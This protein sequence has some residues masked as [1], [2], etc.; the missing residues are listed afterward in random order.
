MS[1][2]QNTPNRVMIPF[3]YG[4][5]SMD[6]LIQI[7]EYGG[8]LFAD[9]SRGFNPPPDF[10]ECRP[11]R[12]LHENG[13]CEP[14]NPGTIST[15]YSALECEGCQ[16]GKSSFDS[17]GNKATASHCYDCPPGRMSASSGVS[18]CALC[19]EGHFSS[20]WGAPACD[21]CG[22]GN[23]TNQRGASQCT[24]CLLYTSDAADE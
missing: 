8:A 16:P 9:G 24:A 3:M 7:P 5:D 13:W 11:G 2:E 14:C 17:L 21:R 19:H 6:T 18:E 22:A 1:L 4:D 23:F 10:F 15:T 12:I 20:S